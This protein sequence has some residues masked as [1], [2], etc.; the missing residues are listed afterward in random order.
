MVLL[1]RLTTVS[2]TLRMSRAEV[3]QASCVTAVGPHQRDAPVPLMQ[4]G[5]QCPPCLAV[6]DR[7]GGDQHGQQ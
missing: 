1:V 5:Q 3:D 2:A 7:G 4:L 6:G